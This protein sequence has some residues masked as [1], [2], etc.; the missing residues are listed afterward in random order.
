MGMNTRLQ[1]EHPV[2]ELITGQD[3]VEWQLQVAAGEELPASQEQ[4][5][6]NGYA[7]DARIP[8]RPGSSG[9]IRS[10][11]SLVGDGQL[12]PQPA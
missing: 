11:V 3:L 2:T 10:E 9:F 4:L 1:V 8:C 6:L 7:L 12:A 5:A